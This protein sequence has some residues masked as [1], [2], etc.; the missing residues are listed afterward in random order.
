MRSMRHL[1]A[2]LVFLVGCASDP[3]DPS[4][5]CGIDLDHEL[6]GL[7]VP[8]VSAG[9]TKGGQLA[10]T[11][12]AGKANLEEDRPVTPDTVFAWASV[13]KTVTATALLI[14]ADEGKL[15][16]D[17]TIDSH[18]PFAVANPHCP[19][20]R[21]T[22]RQLLTHTSSIVDN[23]PVY[24]ASYVTTGDSPVELGAFLE[25][26]LVPAGAH[27]D[28]AKNY[29]TGCPGTVNEYSNI[30]VGLIGYLVERISGTP[31]DAF[32]RDRIF[33]P[34]GM[35][36]ASF[37]MAALDPAHVAM[38][39]GASNQVRRTAPVGATDNAGA[40]GAFTA[41]GHQGFP[42]YPDGLLRASVPE[43]ARFLMMLAGR[44]EYAGA[45][46]LSTATA[47]EMRRVQIPALDDSQGLILYYDDYGAH[48]NML[49]HEGDDPGTSSLM[50]FDPTTGDGALLVGNGY[51]YDADE[52]SDAADAL[53]GKLFDEARRR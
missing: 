7:Q 29:A 40:P 20:T 4:P 45:R 35:T 49:G 41:L 17:D 23:M 44:G 38:P 13:S 1:L 9:I 52:D 53:L 37:R 25:S 36:E 50:F 8:G 47:D 22:F 18:L 42:T 48:P 5:S 16:L 10:C 14:L 46:I 15:D 43:L 28:A 24:E 11:K 21:I 3:A 2:P 19:A 30:G 6:A 34:L 39:Y 31:F 33:V 32:V 26:Y 12:T 27:Y 51:W